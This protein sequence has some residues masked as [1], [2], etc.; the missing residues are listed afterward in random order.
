MSRTVGTEIWRR[1]RGAGVA[2]KADEVVDGDEGRRAAAHRV[3]QRHQLWHRGHLH[4]PG[5]V[6]PEPAADGDADDDDDPARRADPAVDGEE[7]GGRADREGHATRGQEVPVAG[8]GGR[9]HAHE[10]DH[11]PGRADEP[12]ETDDGFEGVHRQAAFSEFGLRGHRLLAEHLEHPV[13]HDV[14]TDDIHRGEGD[15]DQAEELAERLG[16]PGGDDHGAHEDDA[17]DRVRARHQR[18]V[19][20]GR[21]LADHGEAA[22]DREDEDRQCGEEFRAHAAP[23]A[24]WSSFFT[25]SERTSPLWVIVTGPAISS[26]GSRLR[27]PSL[28]SWSRSAER[29]R[30]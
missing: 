3:E 26:A 14:A 8:R 22:Q 5:G 1:D 15:G 9:V 21:D 11:E 10:A 16:G 2:G 20:G 13:G 28:T 12:D 18:R 17:V 30:A 27:A 4:G 25:A 29:F 19:E 6:E 7:D 24:G 23:P